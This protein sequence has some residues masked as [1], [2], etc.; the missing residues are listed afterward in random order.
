MTE[1]KEKGIGKLTTV[2]VIVIIIVAAGIGFTMIQGGGKTL[3]I[4]G[5]T[6]VRPLAREWRDKFVENNPD[7]Q[8]TVKGGGS[9]KGVSDVTKGL[10][11]IGM[12]SSKTLVTQ[13]EA[14]VAHLIAYD[15]ILV[16]V[17]EDNPILN[18]LEENGIKQSTLKKIYSGEITN[19]NEIPGIDQDQE[20]FNYTRSDE[21][22]TAETFADFENMTQGD[23]EGIGA[24]GNSGIKEAVGSNTWGIGYVGA[25]YAFK[26]SIEV[27]P[28][29]GNNDGEIADYERIEDFSDLSSDI[30]NYPIQRGLYFATKGEPTKTVKTFIDWCK[31]EGQKY[32]ADV[33]YIPISLIE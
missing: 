1:L 32:V 27:I 13:E 20:I 9:G 3:K 6:T 10:S 19:W 8:I 25:K 29:D 11:D 31:D 7:I 12:S 26:G 21:S 18:V 14:L 24:K 2:I 22:G 17:N 28:I 16:I 23:L 30:K 33:G 15:G 4:S 5:S